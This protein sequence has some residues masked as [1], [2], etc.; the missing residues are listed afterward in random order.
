MS[1]RKS[2]PPSERKQAS[3]NAARERS[4]HR[5]NANTTKTA[6]PKATPKKLKMLIVIVNRGKAEY[7]V[8]FLQSYEINLQMVIWGQGTANSEIRYAL[9][10][11]DSDKVVIWAIVREDKA[12][13]ALMALEEKFEIIRNGKGIA[14]TIPLSSIA[15]LS[16]YNFLS[17][18]RISTKEDTHDIHA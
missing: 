14:F 6:S 12:H 13:E 4:D 11:E 1:D 9:G 10:L 18:N 3:A 2:L 17:N 5:K 15:G 16:S 7:Y 8:D